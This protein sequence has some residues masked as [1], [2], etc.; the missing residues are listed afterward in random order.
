M[1][2]LYRSRSDRWISGLLGGLGKH[3]GI[4]STALRVIA[5]FSIFFTGGTT[6][7]IYLVAALVISKEPYVP[8]DPYYNGGWAA[9][10]YNPNHHNYGP[11]GVGGNPFN[12]PG[13]QGRPSYNG[14]GFG[15]QPPQYGGGQPGPGF[16]QRD[17]SN[18]DSM[19]E[20]IEK[21]AMKKELEELR[22]KLSDYEK[23]EV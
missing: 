17:S 13:Y 10:G 2:R 6:I 1:N 5:V 9:G 20:D 18:L 3:F 21:K 12:P 22:K 15:G 7:F 23:G 8:Y 11:G 4:S 14:N 16:G 19:M